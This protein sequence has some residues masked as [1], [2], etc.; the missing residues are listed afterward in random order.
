MTPTVTPRTPGT[1]AIFDGR[2]DVARSVLRGFEDEAG[3]PVPPPDLRE[4]ETGVWAVGPLPFAHVR[5]RAGKLLVSEADL[6]AALE[7]EWW[8]RQVNPPGW[9]DDTPEGVMWGHR[10][11]GIF[12]ALGAAQ[13]KG[14]AG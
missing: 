14:E 7:T 6:A 3:N 5:S 9:T 4:E 8:D 2:P 10:A 11:K 1:Y 13:E 12:A